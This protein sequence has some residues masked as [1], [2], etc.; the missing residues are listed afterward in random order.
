MRQS[1]DMVWEEYCVNC[2]CV[3]AW[4]GEVEVVF[5]GGEIRWTTMLQCSTTD[6]EEDKI[7]TQELAVTNDR[8]KREYQQ[9]VFQHTAAKFKFAHWTQWA[10]KNKRIILD[11][12]GVC[13]IDKQ[14]LRLQTF[15]VACGKHGF[16]VL[17]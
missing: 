17:S 12:N 16:K 1:L 14:L 4:F 2:R 8:Y 10:N 6:S 9:T 7:A 3:K 5:Q 13:Y 11:L 15:F